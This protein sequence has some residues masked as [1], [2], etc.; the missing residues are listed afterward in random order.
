M[1]VQCPDLLGDLPVVRVDQ[2]R[3]AA[4]ID[5]GGEPGEVDLADVL[6]RK[7]REVAVRIPL[8]VRA[9]DMHVVE[10]EQQRAAAAARDVGE[11]FRFGIC[12]GRERLSRVQCG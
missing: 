10:V 12:A 11:K 2:Q 3:S 6:E 7:V 5:I 8:L 1:V 9:G 4:L